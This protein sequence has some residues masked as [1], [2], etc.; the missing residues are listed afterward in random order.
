PQAPEPR[1]LVARRMNFS[2]ATALEDFDCAMKLHTT[3][4]RK[5]YDRVFAEA[6]S[7]KQI[8]NRTIEDHKLVEE[9]HT[10]AQPPVDADTASIYAAASVFLPYL[11]ARE[12]GSRSLD[13]AGLAE[14]L[15][16][17]AR[18]SVNPHRAITFMARV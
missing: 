16:K 1:A 14:V 9:W 2:G 4:V 7:R 6:E 11:L 12:I 5:A 8:A 17:A 3:N 10:S 18:E 13:V 15:H